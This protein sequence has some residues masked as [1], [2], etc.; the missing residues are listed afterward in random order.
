MKGGTRNEHEE[1]EN[2]G[3]YNTLAPNPKAINHLEELD[4]DGYILV[5]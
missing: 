1:V 3:L 4:V 2:L 5:Y